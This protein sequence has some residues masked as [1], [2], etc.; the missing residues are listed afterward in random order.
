MSKPLAIAAVTA[1]FAQL[2]DRVTEEPTLAG[3]SVSTGSPDAVTRV[4]KERHLNLFLYAISPS[5][6]WRNSHVS[7]RS[8]GDDVGKEPPLALD[9]HYL[10]TAYGQNDDEIDAHHLMGSAMSIVHANPVVTSDQIRAAQAAH[11]GVAQSNLADQ[12]DM[13]QITLQRLSIEELSRVWRMFQTTSYRLSVTY[14]ASA[15]LA[16]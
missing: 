9:L 8:P 16:D 1:A 4:S 14:Q 2:L 6:E 10:L 11:L 13:V 3:V 15:A 5:A 7:F 12:V